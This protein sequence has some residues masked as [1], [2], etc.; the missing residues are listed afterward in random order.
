M[1]VSYFL[2][3]FF[4]VVL[5]FFGLS[6]G[7]SLAP[8]SYSEAHH[9]SLLSEKKPPRVPLPYVQN[10]W[11]DSVYEAMNDTQRLGQLFMVAAHAQT[12]KPDAKLLKLIESYHIGG[13][14][15]MKGTPVRQALHTNAYQQAATVPLLIAMDAE[16][17]L[18]M[19]LDS[20][21]KYPYQMTLGAI[22]DQKLIYE[23]G[24]QI[25]AQ[26]RRLGVHVS[27]SP[28]VDIN[29]NPHNPVISFRSFGENKHLVAEKGIA[30]MQ[31]LQDGGVLACA[32]HFPGHGDTD[33]DSHYA[34][35]VVKASRKQLDTLE[36]VPFKRLI[37]AGVGS[38]MVAH[39]AIPSLDKTPNRASTLSKE[40]VQKLLKDELDFEGLVFTDALNMKGVADYYLPGEVDALALLAGNDILLYSMDVPVAINSIFKALEDDRISWRSIEKRVKRMLAVKYWVGLQ[41]KRRVD[42]TGLYADLNPAAAGALQQRI[43]EQ[44][45]TLVKNPDKLVPLRARSPQK[46]LHIGVGENAGATA[47]YEAMG[48]YSRA[49]HFYMPMKFDSLMLNQL[50]VQMADYDEVVVSWHLSSQRATQLFGLDIQTQNRMRSLLATKPH[51]QLVFGNAYSLAGFDM[52]GSLICGFEEH[53]WAWKAAAQALFG[54]M[55]FKGQ[56]PVSVS[57]D[58]PAGCGLQTKAL[59]NRQLRFGDPGQ[60]GLRP[61][62]FGR[63]D[64]QVE[65]AIKMRALPGAQL[66][67]A[68]GAEVIYAKSYGFT[69]Y[70]NRIPVRQTHVYDLASLSKVLGT[71][72]GLMQ[73]HAEGKLPIDSSLGFFLPETKAYPIGSRTLRE[74]MAH[75]AGLPAFVPFWKRTFKGGKPDPF[76]YNP[77]PQTA[78]FTINDELK[79]KTTIRDSVFQWILETPLQPAGKMVYSD[80]G[81]MLLWRVVERITGMPAEAYVEQQFFEPL[82]CVTM[83]YNPLQRRGEMQALHP[84]QIAPTEQDKTFRLSLLHGQVHDPIAALLGGVAGHAG[85]FA[86]A[87]DVLRLCAPLLDAEGPLPLSTIDLFSSPQFAGN[88]R[89]LLW[90]RPLKVENGL[91]AASGSKASPYSFGHAGFTG[92]FVWIDPGNDLVLV[93]LSNRVH[94]SAQPNLLAQLNLRT[95]LLDEV[96][97]M[98]E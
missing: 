66:M 51:V 2:S 82:Q 15:F 93:F 78:T 88:R 71:G 80:L 20:T 41:E 79:I 47:F 98:M 59:Q 42:T 34:L 31:G 26:S 13:L 58:M 6:A 87:A 64:R 81:P 3:L 62:D 30:Y 86:H 40:V 57:P 43:F 77:N 63:I 50:A 32:K 74:L 92:T 89:G 24:R 27:F 91:V 73:L 4:T 23:M 55:P 12:D 5:S 39:L 8:K 70:Q 68:R 95:N 35:P 52:G 60:W 33:A 83:G 94:P 36:L 69:D 22:S 65:Q 44:A 1:R 53:S 37:R 28:V 48:L 75:Q 85:L 17:G 25:A 49:D 10:E 7:D 96:I 67:I 19:R 72:L 11:V 16:W 45:I 56:L 97:G 21:V 14:I 90:D 84:H 61:S 38:V 29:N 18:A 46:R 76:W 9:Q 54:V